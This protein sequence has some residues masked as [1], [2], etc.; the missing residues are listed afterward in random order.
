MLIGFAFPFHETSK[1]E[2]NQT[3]P[4]SHFLLPK[5]AIIGFNLA[6]ILLID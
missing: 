2:I 5:L 4:I 1:D 6:V 3:M